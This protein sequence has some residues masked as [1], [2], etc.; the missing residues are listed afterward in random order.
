[1]RQEW[2]LEKIKLEKKFNEEQLINVKIS[3][4]LDDF[5]VKI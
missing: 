3:Q 1:M 4:D 2:D 5:K